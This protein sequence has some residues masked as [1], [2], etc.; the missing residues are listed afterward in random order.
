[1]LLMLVSLVNN[2]CE[3]ILDIEATNLISEKNAW[4]S[5]TDARSGLLGAYATLRT[6]FAENEAYWLY[7]EL[8]GNAFYQSTGRTDL[9]AVINS[10]LNLPY[11]V[12]NAASN[13]RKFY[14]TIN[15]AFLF[16]EK[17]PQILQ[18]DP[19]YTKLN[20][21]VDIAQM[22]A[23]IGFT[24]FQLVRIWGDVPLVTKSYEGVFPKIPR[25]K[26]VAV[27][28][29]AEDLLKEAAPVLPF[30]YGNVFSTYFSGLYYGESLNRW[31]GAL[32]TRNAAYAMLAHIAAW[33]G[34]YLDALV[35]TK[36]VL[37]NAG[38][39]GIYGTTVSDLAAANGFFFHIKLSQVFALGMSWYNNE[40]TPTGH[41]ETLTL[42]SPLI[43]RTLP[44]IYTPLDNIINLYSAFPI[45]DASNNTV[46]ARFYID[47]NATPVTPFFSELNGKTPFLSKIKV[48]GNG[49]DNN[50]SVTGAFAVYSSPIVF[51]RWEEIRLLQAEAY[52]ALG[53]TKNAVDIL[54]S[55]R[56]T[57][58]TVASVKPIPDNTS[59]DEL[60]D[61]VFAERQ[62]EL[63]G[64]GWF[65]FDYVRYNKLK[66]NNAAFNELYQKGGIYWPVAEEVLG[67][68][69]LL[70]QT[71]YWK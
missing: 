13:W 15:A 36:Y 24:Y 32:I 20:N 39:S 48:V 18:S 67:Q 55:F 69:N 11:D 40:A 59:S 5:I 54:N 52:A 60:V 8:R 42:A 21:D 3:K 63:I 10:D 17:S 19:Q 45:Q 46:D 7:G 64:E 1:M 53:E 27:L 65:W 56:L 71:E 2:G 12:L 43:A 37:D 66:G 25:S 58:A 35:Y 28:K 38:Q 9:Q 70:Q 16:I 68:N 31:G 49:A 44:P 47:A 61:I 33:D 51:T 14:A 23:L 26:D 22:K 62:K 34:R 50:S 4:K 29:Y 6:A 57:R 41:I 30:L